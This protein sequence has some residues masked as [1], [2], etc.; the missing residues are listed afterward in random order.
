VSHLVRSSS[1]ARRRSLALGAVVAAGL[2]VTGCTGGEPEPSPTVEESGGSTPTKTPEPEP[3][4][5]EPAKPERPA[6]MDNDDA[7][8]AAAA[9]EYF[10][11]LYGYTLSTLDSDEWERLS[12]EACGFCSETLEQVN[13]LREAGGKHTG[14]ELTLDIAEPGK[15]VR[16]EQTGIRPLDGVVTQAAL[17]VTDGSGTEIASEP[18]GTQDVRVEVGRHDGQWVI[19]ELAPIPEG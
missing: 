9:A 6:A 11:S 18:A 1:R 12:H 10:A 4:G 3:T 8:G 7:E 5:T 17:T 16:D 14:G 15:Y 2:V 13:W 19:V